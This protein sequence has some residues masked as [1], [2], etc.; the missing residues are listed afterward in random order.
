MNRLA[1][2]RLLVLCPFPVGRA[3]GQRLKYEP[4]FNDW[5][6][7]G[8][9]ITVSCFMPPDLWEVVYQP[10]HLW[11]KLRGVM[12]G[13]RRRW[14]DLLRLWQYDCV[15]LFMW[16]T[17]FGPPVYERLV[18]WLA[19]GLVYDL[20]D[21]IFV[22]Q[23]AMASASPNRIVRLIKGPGKARYLA[24]VA[25]A[26][27]VASPHMVDPTRALNR[28]GAVTCIPPSLDTDRICP[29]D[30]PPLRDRVVI[31]WTGTFSSRPYLDMLADVLRQLAARVPFT[32]RVIGN[33]DYDLPGVDLDVVQ[34]SA[35]REAEDLQSLDIGVYPL[36]DDEWTRGKAGL[37]IIQ[38]Q[39]AGLACVAS[40]VPLSRE[41][42]REGETG[43]LVRNDA[44]WLDRLERLV[45]DADL[46]RAMGAAGRRDAVA[47][48]SQGVIAPAYRAV[49]DQ[50][51]G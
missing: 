21:N 15:Y 30:P 23:T 13:Y 25:D 42:I 41:Q 8:W 4:Y 39:A 19:R 49:L 5:V 28:N 34:W 6:A 51:A 17:P 40:D 14:R 35:A 12:T 27:I 20:E 37:K 11:D 47:Q 9:D 18:R 36:P 31:G 50:A 43:F 3:A 46:R 10:G 48:Y 44:E 26:V 2:R 22:G 33:F 29:A 32:L 24:R 7:Q 1:R 16:G 45:R 38:Y